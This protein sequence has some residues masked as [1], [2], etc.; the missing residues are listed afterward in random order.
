LTI[1]KKK[2]KE[3]VG[4]YILNG[5]SCPGDASECWNPSE[6]ETKN[7]DFNFLLKV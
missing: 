6:S 7:L 4:P 3:W 5:S 1:S 2:V